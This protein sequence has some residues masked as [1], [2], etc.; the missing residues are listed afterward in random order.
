MPGC[1]HYGPFL[2]DPYPA[3]FTASFVLGKVLGKALGW[4][5]G[6]GWVGRWER[7]LEAELTATLQLAAEHSKHRACGCAAPRCAHNDVDE[8]DCEAALYE[9][10]NSRSC[11]CSSSAPQSLRPAHGVDRQ[12][13]ACSDLLARTIATG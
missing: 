12:L 7:A 4:G 9:L 3:L 10:Q 6:L 8:E 11:Y 5:L 1:W 13:A 2:P